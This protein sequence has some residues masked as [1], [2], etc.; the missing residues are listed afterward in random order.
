MEISDSLTWEEGL[1][2]PRWDV[3][4]ARVEAFDGPE[5]RHA[6]WTEIARRWLEELRRALGADYRLDES[7]DFFLLTPLPGPRADVLLG[8]AGRC[9]RALLE[10]LPGVTAFETPGKQVVV[11]LAN[12]GTYYTY[13]APFY[14]EGRFGA[15]AGS[16][17]RQ[18]YPHIALCGADPNTLDSALAHELTHAS[19]AHL[20]LPL[21]VEEGL[22]QLFEH[23]MT[24]RDLLVVGEKTARQHKRYWAARGLDL[25]WYGEGFF[26]PDK[27]QR[28]SYELAE[29]LMRLLFSDHRPRWFGLV[30]EPQ[31]RLFA[32]LREAN[33]AD[34]GGAAARKHLGF[35]LGELAGRFLGPGHWSPAPADPN[36]GRQGEVV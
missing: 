22:T 34:A 14:P 35:G 17:V 16:Y 26:Q 6:A 27:A 32:F 1:P 10:S 12:A 9:R 28:L 20:A 23:D 4:A 29:I 25:F 5:A 7:E 3:L 13:L 33:Q 31:R 18:G 24:G 21:W 15:S 30:R 8:L 19:L 36:A 11:A 2:R